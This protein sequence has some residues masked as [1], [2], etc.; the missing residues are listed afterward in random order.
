MV[1]VNF[2]KKGEHLISLEV[3]GHANYAD[4][5][6]DLVC[7]G[8]SAIVIGAFNSFNEM[9]PNAFDFIV[10]DNLLRAVSKNYDSRNHELLTVVYYQLK[11][12]EDQYSEF[13]NIKS[14]EV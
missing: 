6:E 8:I 5:G 14:M 10:E 9:A 2:K 4:K 3:S 11:T 13:I 7:A 1:Q 12:V